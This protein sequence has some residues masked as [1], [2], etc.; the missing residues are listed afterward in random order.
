VRA[1]AGLHFFY[2]ANHRTGIATLRAMMEERGVVENFKPFGDFEPRTVAA[3]DASKEERRRITRDEI[4]E[5]DSLYEVW[6]SYFE[7]VLVQ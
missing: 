6:R 2:D 4:Y 1:F 5:K 3:L 7:D